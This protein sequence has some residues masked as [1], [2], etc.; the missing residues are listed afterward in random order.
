MGS[1]GRSFVTTGGGHAYLAALSTD[2]SRLTQLTGVRTRDTRPA[3]S[4][5]GSQIL[6]TRWNASGPRIWS[7]SANGSHEHLLI[8]DATQ[9]SWSGSGRRFAFVRS[10]GKD[11]AEVWIANADGKGRRG[12]SGTSG[13]DDQPA[14]GSGGIAFV[15]RRTGRPQ[16]FVMRPNGTHERP[17]APQD[18]DQGSPCWCWGKGCVAFI[19]DATDKD[20]PYRDVAPECVRACLADPGDRFRR[21]ADRCRRRNAGRRRGSPSRWWFQAG[22]RP[23]QDLGDRRAASRA[24]RRT[25]PS[26]TATR[27]GSPNGAGKA[28]LSATAPSWP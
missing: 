26:G 14:W 19:S 16:V 17:V 21:G 15:S 2:G 5:D 13:I 7:M 11:E 28:A 25:L 1:S 10:E 3:I 8:A 20:E 23:T 4:P 18:A 6:F 12:L 24:S 22:P 27:T 9:A